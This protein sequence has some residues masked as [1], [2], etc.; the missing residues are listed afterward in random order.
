MYK[1]TNYTHC[2]EDEGEIIDV[3]V[4]A[5]KKIFFGSKLWFIGEKNQDKNL[6]SKSSS[7]SSLT[8]TRNPR[9]VHL[10]MDDHVAYDIQLG[11][12]WTCWKT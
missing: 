10:K 11:C 5:C 6:E 2:K 4:T 1:I 7:N 3:D 12:Y 9:A 8:P